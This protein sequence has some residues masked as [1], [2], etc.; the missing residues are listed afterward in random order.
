M[1]R[2]GFKTKSSR[3]FSCL[4]NF[5][6]RPF[7]LGILKKNSL[8]CVLLENNHHQAVSITQRKADF[9]IEFVMAKEGKCG[10]FALIP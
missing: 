9:C 8:F 10:L 2:E 5:K 4:D 1:L 3:T 6:T 7:H